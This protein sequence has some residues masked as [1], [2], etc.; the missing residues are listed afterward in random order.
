MAHAMSGKRFVDDRRVVQRSRHR[1]LTSA[2]T[3]ED[4]L[5]AGSG[6]VGAIV[7]GVSGRQIVS[8]AHERNFLPANPRPAAPELATVLPALRAA[9]LAGDGARADELMEQA[10]HRSGLPDGL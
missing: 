3:W 5:I 7:H 2:P 6:V 8:I 1:T 9:L 4:G 10:A